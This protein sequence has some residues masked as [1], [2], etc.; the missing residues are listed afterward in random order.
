MYTFQMNLSK[1]IIL[2]LI[3]FDIC[4]ISQKKIIDDIF[5]NDNHISYIKYVSAYLKSIFGPYEHGFTIIK[6]EWKCA[7][8]LIF[9]V[10]DNRGISLSMLLHSYNSYITSSIISCLQI[11][12]YPRG[13]YIL[14]LQIDPLRNVPQEWSSI[15]SEVF[16]NRY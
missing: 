5:I 9:I 1:P 11:L 8:N 12:D 2:L 15:F 16:S 4:I 6:L 13:E 10:E 14:R 3:N 7:L